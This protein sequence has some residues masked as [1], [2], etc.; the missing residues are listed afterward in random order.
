MN[1]NLDKE[2]L[3]ALV[4]GMNPT[5]DQID[6]LQKRKLGDYTGGFA[7][8]WTWDRFSLKELSEQDL[9]NLY[10][11]LKFKSIINI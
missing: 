11:Q 6:R 8:K 5:Y 3:V 2:G 9:Y 1:I 7:D 10:L 4:S